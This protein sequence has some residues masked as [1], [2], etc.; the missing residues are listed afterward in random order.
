MID[1]FLDLMDRK[2][3]MLSLEEES[4]K[5]S[6]VAQQQKSQE[7]SIEVEKL[8]TL[9]RER[10]QLEL[11]YAAMV[12]RLNEI[13]AYES[14]LWRNMTVLDPPALGEQ[15]A[16]SLPIS[17]AGG[18]L[19]GCLVGFLYAGMKELSEKTYRSSDEVAFNAGLQHS[20]VR[21]HFSQN[22]ELTS[23]QIIRVSHQRSLIC[24]SLHPR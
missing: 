21:F 4:L 12:Q 24:I 9:Q 22:R 1:V 6:L 7:L 13:K 15:V 10:Q 2:I 14:H 3:E 18:L 16:P 11:G 20:S 8:N 17:L 5:E 19:L 23:R